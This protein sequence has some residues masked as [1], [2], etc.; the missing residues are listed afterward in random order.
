MK[1][2]L[3]KVVSG[4]L[5]NGIHSNDIAILVGKRTELDRLQ[6]TLSD[7]NLNESNILEQAELEQKEMSTKRYEKTLRYLSVLFTLYFLIFVYTTYFISCVNLMF[8]LFA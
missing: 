5:Q 6:S 2:L 8:Y 7:I 4:L 1:N 3:N